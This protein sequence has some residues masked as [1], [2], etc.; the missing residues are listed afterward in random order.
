MLIILIMFGGIIVCLTMSGCQ[1]EKLSAFCDKCESR[2]YDGKIFTYA[3]AHM[4]THFITNIHTQQSP[5]QF[6]SYI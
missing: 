4:H 1:L 3:Y 6:L 2:F 5:P